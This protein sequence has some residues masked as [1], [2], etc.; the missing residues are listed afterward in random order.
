MN[1]DVTLLEDRAN[2]FSDLRAIANH[3]LLRSKDSKKAFN[4]LYTIWENVSGDLWAFCYWSDYSRCGQIVLKV[5]REVENIQIQ[6]QLLGELGYTCLETGD[7]AHAQQY[8]QESLQKYQLLQD[9]YRESTLFR[10]LGNLHLQQ[11]QSEVALEYYQRAR[12][13]LEA[14]RHD[15]PMDA[16]L[17]YQQAEL[18]NVMGCVYLDLQK[19][20]E[21]Y[22][23]LHLSLKNYQDL[24]E[25][26]PTSE[27]YYTNYRYYLAD[28]LLNLGRW[29]FL[30]GDYS[31]ARNYY[32]ECLLF[33]QEIN[34]NDTMSGVL[35]SLAE[36]AEVE[37]N[38]DRAIELATE[39]EQ[40]A[41]LEI[42][43]LRDR[44]AC[45]KERLLTD[46]KFLS[47]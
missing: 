16:R 4:L 12:E 37:G 47:L 19:F 27:N 2:I 21:S 40:V 11:G 5:A 10:Y 26:Y 23:H 39:A 6:A 34:R 7:F 36:L 28:P 20:P 31:Q 18:Q 25:N 9:F 22:A 30:S 15:S 24:I 42:K 41:G 35:L 13:V 44:A 33:C 32:Q 43:I 46:A 17:A 45:Y 1:I 14:H 3:C 8:F 38:V 29:H